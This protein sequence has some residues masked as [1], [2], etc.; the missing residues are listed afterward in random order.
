VFRDMVSIWEC[1]L[2]KRSQ[3]QRDIFL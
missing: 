1:I 3:N 2:E